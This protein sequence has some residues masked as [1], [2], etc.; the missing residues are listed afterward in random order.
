[1]DFNNANLKTQY[2]DEY[3]GEPQ[4]NDFVRAAMNAGMSYFSERSNEAAAE[5]ADTKATKD[6]TSVCVS[7]VQS[8]KGDLGEPDAR[9][10]LVAREVAKHKIS[11][12]TRIH[13]RSR[14]RRRCS[15]GTQPRG[16]RTAVGAIFHRHQ[17]SLLRRRPAEVHLHGASEGTQI[18]GDYH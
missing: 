8:N 10:Q 13:L 18:G 16:R 1:M 12:F 7:W 4:P 15:Q 3:T 6:A 5:Y 2:V 11:A 9:A 17:E 14:A